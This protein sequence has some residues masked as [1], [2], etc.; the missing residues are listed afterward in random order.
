MTSQ[1][2]GPFLLLVLLLNVSLSG[3]V[4]DHKLLTQVHEYFP[5]AMLYKFDPHVLWIQTEVD[6]ISRKFAEK[7][8]DTFLI[9]MESQ[10]QQQSLGFVHLSDALGHDGYVFL[11]LG[12]RQGIVVWDRRVNLRWTLARPQARAWFT[13][14]L[15]YYPEE[16]QIEIVRESETSIVNQERANPA[17]ARTLQDQMQSSGTV[18]VG[19]TIIISL[20]RS[21]SS[22]DAT[23]GQWA[24][25]SVAEDVVVGA[26]IV[27]PVGSNAS[28]SVASVHSETPARLWLRLHS[29]TINGKQYAPSSNLAGQTAGPLDKYISYPPGTN[30]RFTLKSPLTI[31]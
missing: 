27:I 20:R 4:D 14:H 18:P 13:E 31:H 15:G 22:K 23:T 24:A 8:F 11:V 28:C 19:T 9:E 1:K 17:S 3:C 16:G 6:G 5:G 10:A 7:T 30:L 21:V 29:V 2:T 12:F 25:C 26:R